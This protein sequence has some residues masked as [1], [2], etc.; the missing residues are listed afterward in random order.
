MAQS[1]RRKTGLKKNASFRRVEA[2]RR[3]KARRGESVK[4]RKD[5]REIEPERR[6]V[7]AL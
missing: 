7:T 5:R 2:I 4:V 3:E 1:Q 6:E